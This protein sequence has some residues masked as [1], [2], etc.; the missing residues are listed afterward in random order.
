MR[1]YLIPVV[2]LAI[3][4]GGVGAQRTEG[5]PQAAKTTA[6]IVKWAE[7]SKGFGFVST[8]EFRGGGTRRFIVWYNP[9]S[10]RAAC[11]VHGYLLDAKKG[12]WVRQ[13]D[14]VFEGTHNVSVEVGAALTIR[15]VEGAVI[16]QE[17]AKG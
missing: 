2:F 4:C 11:H 1:G 3:P 5:S 6:D 13:L 10:G 7:S 12:N 16:Y 9:Y 17:K 14:R 15:D 8:V